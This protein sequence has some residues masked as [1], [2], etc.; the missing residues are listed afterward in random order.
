MSMQPIYG[1]HLK[2][3]CYKL[4]IKYV[5]RRKI[6]ETTGIHGGGMKR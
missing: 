4:V 2:I 3:A 1:I 6:G 5:E